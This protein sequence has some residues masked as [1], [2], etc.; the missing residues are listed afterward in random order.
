M[1]TF[2]PQSLAD[3]ITSLKSTAAKESTA[4]TIVPDYRSDMNALNLKLDALDAAIART[5]EIQQ[6]TIAELQDQVA[7]SEANTAFLGSVD[8]APAA[9][10]TEKRKRR[11]KAEMAVATAAPKTEV[12]VT[13]VE[14][15]VAAEVSPPLQKIEAAITAEVH[16][17]KPAPLPVELPTLES[18]G[19]V[20]IDAVRAACNLALGRAVKAGEADGLDAKAARAVAIPKIK[21]A[22]ALASGKGDEGTLAEVPAGSY[23]ALVA[24]LEL[25][26]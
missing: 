4:A 9:T 26:G 24:A 8:A 20:D 18:T 1:I 7:K 2:T 15:P 16:V 3:L 11:T 10:T 17:E 19:S 13:P 12:E 5:I 21:A 22:I 25:I 14:T 6:A 23:E